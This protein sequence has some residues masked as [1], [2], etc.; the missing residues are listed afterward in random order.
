[1]HTLQIELGSRNYPIRIGHGLLGNPRA[2]AEA[3]GR[4][5]RIITDQNVAAHYL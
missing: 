5:C 2:F 1:M 4:A 3:H